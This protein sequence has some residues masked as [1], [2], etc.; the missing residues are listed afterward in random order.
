MSQI[1]IIVRDGVVSE[2]I[3]DDVDCVAVLDAD[4]QGIVP[5]VKDGVSA[6]NLMDVQEIAF[7]PCDRELVEAYITHALKDT[8]LVRRVHDQIVRHNPG[9]YGMREER[10]A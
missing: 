8:E 10:Q 4:C 1:V 6:D 2:I 9:S 3:S 5:V 7:G